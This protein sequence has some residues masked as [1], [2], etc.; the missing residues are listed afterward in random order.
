MSCSTACEVGCAIAE[1][2][3]LTPDDYHFLLNFVGGERDVERTTYLVVCNYGPG[4]EEPIW[5]FRPYKKGTPCSK[6]PPG[7]PVCD[8]VSTIP[9]IYH[10]SL[11][12]DY[13][14]GAEEETSIPGLCCNF[15]CTQLVLPT[16]FTHPVMIFIS[17][18]YNGTVPWL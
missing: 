18:W 15:T 5:K 2:P 1:C 3:N 17:S 9:N 13:V 7:L 4:F 14:V 8:S 10:T 16:N 11:M 12:G 6:C